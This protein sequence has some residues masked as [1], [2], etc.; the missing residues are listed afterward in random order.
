MGLILGTGINW[1]KLLV[2]ALFLVVYGIAWDIW[3]TKHGRNDKLWIWRFNRNV[4]TG[5]TIKHH[6]L[7]EYIFGFGHI[8]W[9]ILFWELFYPALI[10]RQYIVI[11]I[12]VLV[13]I[14]EISVSR[15]FYRYET[16]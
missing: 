10:N 3:A 8:I 14:W 2:F 13:S 1:P 11:F 6:P 5:V 7:E 9:L 16:N 4:I 15:S 12:L